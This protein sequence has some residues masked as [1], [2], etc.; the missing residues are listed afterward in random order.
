[1]TEDGLVVG[2]ELM[3]SLEAFDRQLLVVFTFHVFIG[4]P[5]QVEGLVVVSLDIEH[6]VEEEDGLFEL[7]EANVTARTLQ[8]AVLHVIVN[9]RQ[10]SFQLPS[11]R[12]VTA[13][14]SE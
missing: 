8:V 14:A 11:R 5:T 7:L 4:A 2:G 6:D 10:E 9:L 12:L 1:M 3:G 13:K